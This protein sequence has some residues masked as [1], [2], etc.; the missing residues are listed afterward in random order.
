M[1]CEEQ[2][3]R[4]LNISLALNGTVEQL[5]LCLNLSTILGNKILNYT[6]EFTECSTITLIVYLEHSFSPGTDMQTVNPVNKPILQIGA[7][8]KAVE[9]LQRLLEKR[10]GDVELE[11]DGIFGETTKL[12]VQV[13]QNRV[14]LKD[15]GVV[16]AKTWKALDAGQRDDLPELRLNSKAEEVARVQSVLKFN[17]VVKETLGSDGYY[18][19]AVDGNFG[20][21]TEQAIKAF[22]KD[23]RLVADGV[24]HTKTWKALMDLATRI[25]HIFL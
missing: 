18:F 10:V 15:D 8:G 7:T 13:F 25:S 22:Q 3:G 12:A 11:I 5:N 23:K 19:G 14:F 21:K 17:Q 16:G 1:F 4:L 20:A 2:T 24:I 6:N 9:E